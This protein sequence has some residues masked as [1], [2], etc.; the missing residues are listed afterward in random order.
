[1]RATDVVSVV[2]EDVLGRPTPG[3]VSGQLQALAADSQGNLWAA[4]LTGISRFDGQGWVGF[5]RSEGLADEAFS[6]VTVDSR[7]GAWA[8]GAN[9]VTHFDGRRWTHYR[10]PGGCRSIAVAPTGDIWATGGWMSAFRF[11]GESWWRYGPEDGMPG[12]PRLTIGR[13]TV[14][15]A[16]VAWIGCTYSEFSSGSTYN[17]ASFDGRQWVL[18]DLPSPRIIENTYGL[19]VDGKNR[20]LV[21]TEYGLAVCD[22][23]GWQVCDDPFFSQARSMSE[24]PA[25]RLWFCGGVTNEV[26]FLAG[27]RELAAI[28]LANIVPL[29]VSADAHGNLW[30]TGDPMHGVACWAGSDIP[31]AV[32][33][34][35]GPTG[36]LLIER[37]RVSPNPFNQQVEVRFALDAPARIALQVFDVTGQLVTTLAQ[38]AYPAGN[39]A[40]VWDAARDGRDLASGVYLCRLTGAGQPI[41][42]KVSLAR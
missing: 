38:G 13:V 3:V 20:L 9:G 6:D 37:L 34:G 17:L 23:G 32:R 26:G 7:G 35:S 11:D 2:A 24:D 15:K 22:G 36:A 21:C 27:E 42:R 10:I 40:V 12:S 30:L 31:T 5:T 28:T 16:G 4:C 33:N 25:G 41:V 29:S 14:D 1:M 18:H 8:S 39:H 19:Y